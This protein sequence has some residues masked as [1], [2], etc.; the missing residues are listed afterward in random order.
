MEVFVVG[1]AVRDVLLGRDPKDLDYVVVGGTPEEMLA[2]GYQSVGK[3]FPVFLSPEG[4]EYALARKERKVAAGYHGFEFD[5]ASDVTLEE[6]LFRRDL[7]INAMAVHV[8]DWEYFI[9]TK[10]LNA[11]T[12]PYHGALH[13]EH[14]YLAPVSEHF[15]EDPVRVLRAARFGARYNFQCTQNLA[16]RMYNMTNSGELDA[17][18]GERVWAEFEKAMGEHYPS[19]FFEV[20]AHVGAY[21]KIFKCVQ[22][23][24]F[25]LMLPLINALQT[26]MSRIAAWS[27]MTP[28]EDIEKQYEDIKA[29]SD[30]LKFSKIVAEMLQVKNDGDIEDKLYD[31]SKKLVKD[32][33]VDEIRPL[34]GMMGSEELGTM[35][36]LLPMAREVIKS[37]NF[38]SLPEDVRVGLKGPEIG[39]AIKEEALKGIRAGK[40]RE[41]ERIKPR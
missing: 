34:M 8:N 7:T 40:E 23:G 38:E 2:K 22:P 36:F 26:P 12:D 4:D 15:D 19:V 5:A 30:F 31:L 3:D 6:D 37:T 32:E 11:V 1:G 14:G 9:K 13:L 29:P 21:S 10:D 18:V 41:F 27:C 24:Q 16:Y 20:L 39:K 28:V 33:W 17:L 25:Q 35:A